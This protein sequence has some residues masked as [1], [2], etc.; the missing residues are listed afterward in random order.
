MTAT[1]RAGAAIALGFLIAVGGGIVWSV[2]L[3][4]NLSIRPALPW[5]VAAAIV[6]LAITWLYLS[7]LGW[8]RNTQA[9]RRASL[10]Q[11]QLSVGSWLA[12]LA[13]ALGVSGLALCALLLA[14]R[15]LPIPITPLPEFASN[16]PWLALVYFGA[17]ALVAGVVEEAAFRGYMLSGVERAWGRFAAYVVVAVAF[18]VLHAGNPEFLYLFPLY[19][20]LSLA[21]SGVVTMC[22]S[23]WPGVIAHTLSDFVSFALLLFT[24]PAALAA[25]L[26]LTTPDAPALALA[27]GATMFGIVS[28]C[29][30]IA[31]KR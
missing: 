2:L 29:G 8:P 5:S 15:L 22:G 1:L 3:G 14:F 10:P 23:V 17:A 12:A 11:E 4:F 24:G 27:A 30:F 7:G 28:V 6:L 20:L 21:L 25:P 31:M 19:F 16:E 26:T 13:A 9:A 18:A